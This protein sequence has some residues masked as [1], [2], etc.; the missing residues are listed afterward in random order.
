M[1]RLAWALAMA[2]LLAGC[3]QVQVGGVAPPQADA[4]PMAPADHYLVL[5]VLR[6]EAGQPV[7][8]GTCD[9]RFGALGAD[10]P[11]DRNG[12]VLRSVPAGA[13]GTVGGAAPGRVAMQAAVVVDGPK[14]V[15]ITLPRAKAAPASSAG[16]SS[17]AGRPRGNATTVADHGAGNASA[18]ALD[19]ATATFDPV[20]DVLLQQTYALAGDRGPFAFNVTRDY[21]TVEF[22]GR[23]DAI[24]GGTVD[25]YAAVTDVKVTDPDGKVV[26]HYQG[27]P[28]AFAV[29]YL[30]GS[31][32][33]FPLGLLHHPKPGPYRMDVTSAGAATGFGLLVDGQSGGAPDFPF[34]DVANGTMRHLSDLRGK[35]VLI[36]LMATWCGP[37][38]DSMPSLQAIQSDYGGRVQV[39]SV[40]MDHS[41]SRD[42]VRAMRDQYHA[43]WVFG[44][45][46]EHIAADHYNTG[47]I[48]SYVVIDR[49]GG[50]LFRDVSASPDTLRE[51]L[52]RGL[53][54]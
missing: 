54:D 5:C 28:D 35:A 14:R 26:L 6:D 53:S 44:V 38:Q 43:T 52:D 18:A 17:G 21:D 48:P 2:G 20:Y 10:V 24:G 4:T 37:C 3:I 33:S 31:A 39:L 29:V 45:D 32:V 30:G 46:T 47:L 16:A 12:S 40:D 49:H 42:T 7:R 25:Y 34:L 15:L 22:D 36:D 1:R 19:N 13:H 11:V 8:D 9:Y 50:L 51:W 41:E 23:Y 27:T